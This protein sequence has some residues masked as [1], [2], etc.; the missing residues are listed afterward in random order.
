M[1]D[2]EG[3]DPDGHDAGLEQHEVPVGQPRHGGAGDGHGGH[4]EHGQ[5][6]SRRRLRLAR[7]A[8]EGVERCGGSR[9]PGGHPPQAQAAPCPDD[10]GGERDRDE[11][12]G[13]A[14]HPQRRPDQA[15]KSETARG[16]EHREHGGVVP[17]GGRQ[18]SGHGEGEERRAADPHV[19]DQAPH[20]AGRQPFGEEVGL[21]RPRHRGRRKRGV[22]RRHQQ[23][24]GHGYQEQPPF[25]GNPAVIG[26]PPEDACGGEVIHGGESD[27][28]AEGRNR[29]DGR[30]GPAS[31]R[32]QHRRHRVPHHARARQEQNGSGELA[33]RIT[34]ADVV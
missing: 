15:L 23:R 34:A 13:R 5:R 29:H 4:G 16:G 27:R 22:E 24:G 8:E 30:H 10:A 25:T 31:Q 21:E 19:I 20:Q 3:R 7:R 28:D 17:A 26:T 33:R 14:V 1:H 9:C 11:G 32:G 18:A 12:R 6:H 2:P